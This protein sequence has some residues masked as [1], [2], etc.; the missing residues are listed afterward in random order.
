MEGGLARRRTSE[1][2]MNAQSSRSHAVLTLHLESATRTSSGLLA[3]K[4]SRLNLVDLAGQ[5]INPEEYYHPRVTV[6]AIKGAHSIG[7]K[8][9]HQC[10]SAN[11][12]SSGP[13]IPKPPISGRECCCRQRA[14]QIQWCCR[15]PTQGGLLHQPVP[16]HAWQGDERAGGGAAQQASAP[17]PLQRLPPHLPAPG[18]SNPLLDACFQDLKLSMRHQLGHTVRLLSLHVRCLAS[19]ECLLKHVA[20]AARTTI[21]QIYHT[22]SR[23]CPAS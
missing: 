15:G 20:D 11:D 22:L 2:R 7:R 10:I 1:T 4:S 9:L 16:H 21:L 14:Q 12:K 17:H 3:V 18:V 5:P 23:C 13:E 19:L 6:Q 8:P